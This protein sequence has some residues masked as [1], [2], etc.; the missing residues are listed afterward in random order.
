M[1]QEPVSAWLGWFGILE[2]YRRRG[3]GSLALE[4]FEA[5]ARKRGYLF[6]RL[7][8]GRFHNDAAKAFYES[9]GYIEEYYD[10]KDDPGSK[11][12]ALSIYSKSLDKKTPIVPWNNKNLHIDEQIL[13]QTRR[14]QSI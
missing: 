9:N 2:K 3:Y 12:E 5:E 14:K 10:C 13:K 8:T 7:Y 11:A 6:A 4:M 1:P